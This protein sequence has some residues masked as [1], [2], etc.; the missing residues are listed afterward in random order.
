MTYG[1]YHNIFEM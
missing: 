1:L